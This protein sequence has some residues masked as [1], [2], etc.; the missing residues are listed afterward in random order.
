MHK[1]FLAFVAV[2]LAGEPLPLT[3]LRP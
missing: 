3:G 1:L 2:S